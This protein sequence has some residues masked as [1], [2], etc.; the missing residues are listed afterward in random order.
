V[1]EVCEEP[2]LQEESKGI[3]F[4]NLILDN[5]KRI[6]LMKLDA[7]KTDRPENIQLQ[8]CKATN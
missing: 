6:Q 7:I 8:G 2:C 4:R 5:I 3:S 1:N